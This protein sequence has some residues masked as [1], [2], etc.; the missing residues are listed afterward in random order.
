M[1]LLVSWSL[2]LLVSWSLGPLGSWCFPAEPIAA[3]ELLGVV[4]GKLHTIGQYEEWVSSDILGTRGLQSCYQFDGDWTLSAPRES[5]QLLLVGDP[6]ISTMAKINA[7]N[8]WCVCCA[9]LLG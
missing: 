7:P 3:G 8:F 1:R 2:G 9:V 4:M 5:Q 6:S